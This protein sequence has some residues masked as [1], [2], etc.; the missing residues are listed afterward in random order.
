MLGQ[1]PRIGGQMWDGRDR[2]S[3]QIVEFQTDEIARLRDRIERRENSLRAREGRDVELA[4]ADD[5]MGHLHHQIEAQEDELRQ[6]REQVYQLQQDKEQRAQ[7]LRPSEQKST[8]MRDQMEIMKLRI[9]LQTATSATASK[10][11]LLASREADISSLKYENAAL[12]RALAS[13]DTEGTRGNGD[14]ASVK[15]S[16][17]SGSESGSKSGS[18]SSSESGSSYQ[19]HRSDR[20]EGRESTHSSSAKAHKGRDNISNSATG[21]EDERRISGQ[22]PCSQLTIGMSPWEEWEEEKEWGESESD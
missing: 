22:T 11:T 8:S 20:S 2:D 6:V 5:D 10:E 12:H 17:E 7:V 18:E 4:K 3:V 13:T 21:A 15:Q 9:A 14:E 1:P 19:S 16:S